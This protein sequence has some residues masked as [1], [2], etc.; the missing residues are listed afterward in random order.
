MLTPITSLAPTRRPASSTPTADVEVM[1]NPQDRVVMPD[2]S[3]ALQDVKPG[4]RSDKVA[5]EGRVQPEDGKYVFPP[6]DDRSHAALSF[7]AVKRTVDVFERVLG[8]PIQWSFGSSPLTI[9]PDE[10]EMLNAFYSREDGSLNFFHAGD[11]VTGQTVFSADS[12]EVVSHECGHAILDS[13]RP[14]YLGA[15]SPD[16]A[17]FHES[18][19][20]CVAM[21]VSLQDDKAV[22]KCLAET[23]GDLSQKNCISNNGENMGIVINHTAGHNVTGGDYGRTAVNDFTWQDPETLPHKG[24]ATHLGSEAHSFSRLWTGA[25][26]DIIKAMYDENVKAGMAG[27]DAL[28]AAGDEGLKLYANLF[29]TAPE[30]DFTYRDMAMACVAADR[31]FDGGKHADLMEAA[32]KARKILP[33]EDAPVRLAAVAPKLS[34]VSLPAEGG[35]KVHRVRVT[36]T[37]DGFGQ[38]TG[39]VVENPVDKDGSLTKD[40]ESVARVQS[41]LKR[42]IDAGRIRYNDPGYKMQFPRDYFDPQ[43]RPYLGA[44]RW[45]DGHMKI[46]RLKIA[47]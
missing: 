32:F 2:E 27:K 28:R 5:V 6:S 1:F 12:G 13:L 24:D 21:L 14:E 30:G 45:E 3:L 39:A 46:E 35:E 38:F 7:A 29:K 16:P 9:K 19:G 47:D 26:Y 31:K 41:N 33:S 20:D 23:G 22:E 40:A 34:F 10:G 44:V 4:L 17:A 43:G 42:L 18:F 8:Q 37:G 25:F 11:P 15:W 36:L